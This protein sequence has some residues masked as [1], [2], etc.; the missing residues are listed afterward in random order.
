MNIDE[1]NMKNSGE[2]ANSCSW[3]FR[4]PVLV[5]VL[6][7]MASVIGFFVVKRIVSGPFSVMTGPSNQYLG[8]PR[9]NN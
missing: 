9:G 7:L 3:C 6:V 8:T 4:H 1:K 5:T 2:A